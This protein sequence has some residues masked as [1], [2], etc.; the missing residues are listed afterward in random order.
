M[1]NIQNDEHSTWLS[2]RN[3]HLATESYSFKMVYTFNSYLWATAEVGWQTKAQVLVFV[4]D[5]Y[6]YAI[7]SCIV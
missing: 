4:N 2:L 6:W 7:H 1:L 5:I 3:D